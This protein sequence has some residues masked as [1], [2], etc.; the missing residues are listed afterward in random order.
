MRYT[1]IFSLILFIL[2]SGCSK[3]KFGAKPSLKFTGVNTSELHPGDI[4]QFKMSFTDA[5]GDISNKMIVQEVLTN[6]ADGFTQEYVVPQVPVQP[7]QKGDII[8]TFGYQN[9]AAPSPITKQTG[10]NTDVD[11]AFFKFV[12]KDLKGNLSDTVTSPLVLI[13]KN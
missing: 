10:C 11:S 1:I 3:D 5:E 8:V 12:L 13:F 9:D 2:I 4:L 7:N 6:C